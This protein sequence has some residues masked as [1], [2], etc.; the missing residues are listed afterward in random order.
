M[1]PSQKTWLRAYSSQW[2]IPVTL[3][4]SSTVSPQDALDLEATFQR[5]APLVVEIGVGH[6][7]TI[8][9]G[10]AQDPA[11]DYLGFEVFPAALASTLGK[12]AH[13]GLTNVRLVRADGV[14]GLTYLIEDHCLEELWVFFPDPWPKTRHHKRRLVSPGFLDLAWRKLNSSGILRLA[15]DWEP[16]AQDMSRLLREDPQFTV[17]SQ[18]RFSTRPMTKFESR[19]AKAGRTIHDFSARVVTS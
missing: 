2:I 13:R 10:A 12:I 19:G 1:T 9:S 17:E 16:Y 14:T 15:T 8:T 6:G 18:Q 7:E 3:G 4:E 5:S 11:R